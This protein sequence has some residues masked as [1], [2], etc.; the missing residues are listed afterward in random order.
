MTHQNTKIKKKP[1]NTA[2]PHSMASMCSDAMWISSEALERIWSDA[3]PGVISI[4]QVLEGIK[5]KSSW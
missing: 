2:F 5:C 1:F 3:L 4:S